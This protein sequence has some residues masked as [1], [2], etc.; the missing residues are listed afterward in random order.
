M[1]RTRL[2]ASTLAQ[3]MGRIEEAGTRDDTPGQEE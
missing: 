2:E 1:Q 3:L